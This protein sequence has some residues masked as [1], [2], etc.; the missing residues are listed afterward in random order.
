MLSLRPL[1]IAALAALAIFVQV[2][3]GQA[4]TANG[5]ATTAAPTY[6]NNSAQPLSLDLT[7]G[8]RVNCVTGCG[9]A[10]TVNSNITQVGGNNV[11]TT[12]PISGSVTTTGTATVSG[13]VSLGA[14]AAS[15]GTVG[16]NAGSAIV[17]KV[18]IDQTTP[19]TTNGVAINA[20]L[21]AGSAIIGN[22]RIDQ[23]TPG[24]T[25]GVQVNNS[26]T[27][28]PGAAPA[29]VLS[30]AIMAASTN[31]TSVKAS[32]G[33]VYN[34]TVYNSSSTLAW[35][36]LYNSASAPT[37]GSGTPVA[38]YLI[39]AVASGGAGSNIDIAAGSA[40]STGIAYCVT[41]LLADAD[42]TATA[43]GTMAVNITYK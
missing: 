6:T 12:L 7:G 22:V 5:K 17:G 23:T 19:G 33:A 35:L 30:S 1:S 27:T 36:K 29:T 9:G 2:D 39:P 26:V 15:V 18:G 41:G 24:T 43:A 4:Q 38:R 13:T 32:A 28:I 40:F 14:G 21:P 11:T 31:A 34:V 25:N 20:A 3:F 16:L 8:L 37:C 10:G 42:T